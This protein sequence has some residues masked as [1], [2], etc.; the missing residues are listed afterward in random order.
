M[1]IIDDIA[2]R[3]IKEEIEP[4]DV[5]E[6]GQ[7]IIDPESIDAPD[8]DDFFN[9]DPDVIDEEYSGFSWP[10]SQPPQ[11]FLLGIYYPMSSPGHVV[12]FTRNIQLFYRS[13]LREVL[14]RVPS[15]SKPDMETAVRLVV[16]KTYYHECFHFDCD[17]L[18]RL[19]GKG[20]RD[21]LME[22]ALAVAWSR[23][24]VAKDR[25]QW[26]TGIGR[27]NALVY[28]LFVRLA[29]QYRSAGYC[30]WPLYADDVRFKAGLRDFFDP[31]N[32]NFLESSGVPVGDVLF[33]MLGKRKENEGF[34]ESGV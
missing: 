13:L 14:R 25:S 30:D 10:V 34:Y 16:L 21:R 9:P 27:M 17:L 32:A 5:D 24:Q 26:N 20:Q 28:N 1:K 33:E 12:L 31:P 7:V 3:I 2:K 6:M 19:F 8:L 15:I 11:P 29:Y 23:M 22:E 4:L 18:R